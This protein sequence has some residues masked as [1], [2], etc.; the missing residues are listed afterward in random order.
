MQFALSTAP[1][2]LL[3][4][5]PPSDSFSVDHLVAAEAIINLLTEVKGLVVSSQGSNADLEK[6]TAD[7]QVKLVQIQDLALIVGYKDVDALISINVRTEVGR[8]SALTQIET[9]IEASIKLFQDLIRG[10]VPE[11]APDLTQLQAAE[12]LLKVLTEVKALV[13]GSLWENVD[14]ENIQNDI[15]WHLAYV[16]V[17]API[18]GYD[19]VDLL[20]PM[21]VG[22]QT[23]RKSA[24]T[25]AETSIDATIT[26]VQTLGGS[27]PE[28]T[29]DLLQLEAAARVR[30]LLAEVESL[31]VRSHEE[32]VDLKEIQTNIEWQL[33]QIQE[34]A[35]FVGYEG[36]DMLASIDVR[37]KA[38]WE[39]A[40]V[41]VEKSIDASISLVQTLRGIVL[42]LTPKQAQL[43][44][45]EAVLDLLLEV[46]ALVVSSF[47][48]NVDTAKIQAGID[49]QLFQIKEL[50]PIAGYEGVDRLEAFDLRNPAAGVAMLEV[51]EAELTLIGEVIN[52]LPNFDLDQRIIGRA[53]DDEITTASGDDM[54]FGR[55][56]DDQID[57]GAGDDLLYGGTGEDWL[58]GGTGND[59]L[60]GGADE[61]GIDGGAGED[62][63]YGD[64]GAD[65]LGGGDGDDTLGGGDVDDFLIGQRGD[66]L[67]FGAAG[68]DFLT[69]DDGN[70]ILHGGT[71]ADDLWG[72]TGDDV[73]RGGED[74]DV[75]RGGSGDD[76]L[77]GGSGD[78]WLKGGTGRD[79]LHGGNGEDTFV[80]TRMSDTAFG[81]VDVVGDFEGAGREGGDVISTRGINVDATINGALSFTFLG[82]LTWE[83]GMA[84]GAGAIWVQNFGTQTR[85][86]GLIDDDKI[87]DLAFRI[88]DG[89]DTTASDYIASD[90][91]L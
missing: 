5:T 47:Q 8:S 42:E 69:G 81:P 20:D 57:A 64:D 60:F 86:F 41:Q 63:L 55:G 2:P 61:D 44:A 85:V 53:G 27:A 38:G 36:V 17:L 19:G 4:Q 72:Y 26:L 91:L 73:L 9:S 87:I 78:D 76:V 79:I 16:Q 1:I 58:I 31:V 28:P 84:A 49:N 89:F 15:D 88:N 6:V 74:D 13:V 52:T 24:L 33:Y 75:L 18:A 25:Q 71:G 39:S 7:I 32:N 65:V 70:D 51:V 82:E 23:G 30:D 80:F 14:R 59:L 3:Q 62:R 46:Q 22:T 56:G 48:T 68:E 12:T 77:Y 34:F 29:A 37:T 21:D 43:E 50:A 54:I 83:E 35:P 40:L 90:F 11:P 67:I 45:A 66:D 10:P